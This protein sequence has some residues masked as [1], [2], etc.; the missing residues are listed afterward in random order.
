MG[1]VFCL[2]HTHAWVSVLWEFCSGADLN[3]SAKMTGHV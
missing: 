3:F 2:T 1:Q